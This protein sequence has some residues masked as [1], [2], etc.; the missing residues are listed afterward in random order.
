MSDIRKGTHTPGGWFIG[1]E[2]TLVH[3]LIHILHWPFTC[4]LKPQ[5]AE[6]V[7]HEQAIHAIAG[8]L[9]EGRA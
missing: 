4:E 2:K 9:V 7:A 6:W 3:E 1:Q 8:A 5:T